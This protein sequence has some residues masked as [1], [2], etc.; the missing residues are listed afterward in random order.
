MKIKILN[1]ILIIDIL[2]VILILSIIFI[3][4]TIARVI[5]GLPFL[6]FFPGYTL[7]AALFIKKEGMD[8]IERIALSVVM[9]IVVVALIGFGLNY[10]PWGIKL[11]PVLY[12]I[13][14][15]VFLM[16]VIALVLRS[17]TFKTNIFT[18]EFNLHFPR[19]GLSKINRYLFII[20]IVA[21][22]GALGVL[23]YSIAVPRI[24]ERFT[25]FY[26]L[27]INGQAQDYPTEYIMDK[28]NITQV[29]YSDGTLD[30]TSGLGIVTLGIVN[31]EYQIVVYSVKMTIDDESVNIYSGGTIKD[32]LGPIELKQEEKWEKEIGIIPLNTGENQKVELLL[33]E[34]T[35]TT[36]KN[37]LRLRINV[38]G[39]E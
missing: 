39:T 9:S 37:S 20:L 15:F 5:L 26:I 6:L 28:G 10:T 13:T 8:N 21:I 35:E 25:E 7:I 34:G 17:R 16:S 38:K 14:T 19:R 3:P 33:F 29:L 18:T 31:H 30:A 36:L 4:S 2:S 24:G 23:S 27:G 1:G 11:E 32:T 22:I 12:S